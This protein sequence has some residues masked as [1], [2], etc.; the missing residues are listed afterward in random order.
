MIFD[1]TWR[2]RRTAAA[3]WGILAL[4]IFTLSQSFLCA[5]A[6]AT[7]QPAAKQG[8]PKK[9]AKSTST[10]L[11]E[12]AALLSDGRVADAK[13]TI[14]EELQ[15]NPANAEAYDLLGVIHVSERDYPAALDSF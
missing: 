9:P 4:S 15:R 8:A 11:A 10:I 3:L 14:Q 1:D 2:P 12:A 5:A 7:Q 6:L 13:S